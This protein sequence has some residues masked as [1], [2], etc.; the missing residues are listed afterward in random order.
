[1]D[2]Y[3]NYRHCELLE[4][5]RRSWVKKLP[6]WYYVHYQGN[7]IHTPKHSIMQYCHVTNLCMYLLYLKQIEILKNE[8][9]A[10]KWAFFE[11][12]LGN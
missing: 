1:M 10:N 2:K 9:T 3:G 5:G 7:E 12:F 8:H 11:I 4:G 6:L